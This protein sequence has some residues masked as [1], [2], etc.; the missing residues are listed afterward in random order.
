MTVSERERERERKP[1]AH[2]R[3]KP[4]HPGLALWSIREV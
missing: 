1:P 4:D 3:Q 2:E